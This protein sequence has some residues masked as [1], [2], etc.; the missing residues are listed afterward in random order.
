MLCYVLIITNASWCRSI[1]PCIYHDTPFTRFGNQPSIR[2]KTNT[3]NMLSLGFAT[4]WYA[5]STQRLLPSA[6]SVNLLRPS[7]AM[8]PRFQ[9]RGSIP[10]SV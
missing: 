9:I 8:H 10:R 7:Y 4:P 1:I 6:A 3:A 2:N 5:G